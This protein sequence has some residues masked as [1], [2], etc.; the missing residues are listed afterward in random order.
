MSGAHASCNTVN[1]D[2][3]RQRRLQRRAL[4]DE[5]L[6]SSL[7]QVEPTVAQANTITDDKRRNEASYRL[8]RGWM[9]RE[10]DVARAWVSSSQLPDDMKERLINRRRG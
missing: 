10:P 6:K 4:R 7:T 9:E 2:V 5:L 1:T 8:V 3:T